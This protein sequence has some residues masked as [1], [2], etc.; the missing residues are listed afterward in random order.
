[1]YALTR[2]K[3]KGGDNGQV[4]NRQINGCVCMCVCVCL[5]TRIQDCGHD[6]GI[7]SAIFL[8]QHELGSIEIRLLRCML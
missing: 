7:A 1:M 5:S 3:V 2:E 8:T 6:I 4:Y